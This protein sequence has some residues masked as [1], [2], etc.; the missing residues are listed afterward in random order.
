MYRK[1]KFFYGFKALA[2]GIYADAVLML[3]RM[4]VLECIKALDGKQR[5]SFLNEADDFPFR[6]LRLEEKE[7]FITEGDLSLVY[8]NFLLNRKDED[9]VKSITHLGW[10]LLL[11]KIYEIDKKADFIVFDTKRKIDRELLGEKIRTIVEIISA[12]PEKSKQKEA[13]FP[14]EKMEGFFQVW[15]KENVSLIFQCLSSADSLYGTVVNKMESAGY[16]H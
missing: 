15:N 16:R 2:A 5:R 4:Q 7:I 8:R 12:K 3:M 6:E 14:F 10:L 11:A 9:G 13:E 1:N